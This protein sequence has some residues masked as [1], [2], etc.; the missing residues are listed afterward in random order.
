MLHTHY[1]AGCLL[2]VQH[3]RLLKSVG[4]DAVQQGQQGAQVVG[5]TASWRGT[6][7]ALQQWQPLG[8]WH[9]PAWPGGGADPLVC[10]HVFLTRLSLGVVATSAGWPISCLILCPITWLQ[11]F[12]Q[13]QSSWG[14]VWL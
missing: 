1:Q 7:G 4:G 3:D 13:T 9:S 14:C 8:V 12:D 2:S 10:P 6:Q 11:A 5:C